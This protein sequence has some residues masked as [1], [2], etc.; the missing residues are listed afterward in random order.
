MNVSKVLRRKAREKDGGREKGRKEGKE[1][2]EGK[3]RIQIPEVHQTWNTVASWSSELWSLSVHR[4]GPEDAFLS[5]KKVVKYGE[6]R[7]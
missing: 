4:S 5:S 2:K 1:I 7:A 6:T 3:M